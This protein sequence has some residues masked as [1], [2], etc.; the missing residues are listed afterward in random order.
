MKALPLHRRL[1]LTAVAIAIAGVIV[2]G[3]LAD[4]LVVRGDEF[5]YRARPS[6]ALRYY[7]RAL[8]F[9]ARSGIAVDRFLFVALTTRTADALHAGIAIA[10][11]YLTRNPRDDVVLMDR[12]MAYRAVGRPELAL[13][14]FESVGERRKD[15]R[16][17]TFAGFAAQAV[18]QTARA[19]VLWKAA[20][21]V[22]PGFPPAKRALERAESE[23]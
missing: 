10:S 13:A 17:L 19:R 1:V 8:W 11:N 15:S 7:R 9:D 18:G 14:D 3:Q 22:A 21:S 20:L 12:A 16:A 4:A 5:L 2:R 6:T 23:R